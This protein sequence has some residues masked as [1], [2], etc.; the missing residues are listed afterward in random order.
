MGALVDGL[1]VLAVSAFFVISEKGLISALGS[2][3]V[4]GKC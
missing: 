3:F 2:C 1:D 4:S